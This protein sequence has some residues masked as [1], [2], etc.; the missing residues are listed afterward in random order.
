LI[1]LLCGR[2]SR[3]PDDIQR[4]LVFNVVKMV[5]PSDL[6]ETGL[7]YAGGKG[8][9][10]ARRVRLDGSTGPIVVLDETA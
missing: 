3:G 2:L 5:L 10:L 6:P 1:G 4:G 7:E 8:A 9:N